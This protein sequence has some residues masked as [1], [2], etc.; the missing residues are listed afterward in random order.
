MADIVIERPRPG[1]GSSST[2]E[3]GA[4]GVIELIGIPGAG[5]TT[6]AGILEDVLRD[7]GLIPYDVVSA[8]RVYAK[9]TWVG[10]VLGRLLAG[11]VLSRALWGVYLAYSWAYVPYFAFRNPRLVRNIVVSQARR[12]GEADVAERRVLFWY[13]RL[14]GSHGF[15][16]SR[17]YPGEVLVLDE[18][19]VHRV[20]Q[21]H[22]SDVERPSADAIEAYLRLVPVPTAV[23]HVRAPRDVCLDRI[24][25]RGLWARYQGDDGSKLTGFLESAD[26][27]VRMAVEAMDRLGWSVEHV[28]NSGDM[29]AIRPKLE[30]LTRTGPV[31]A[32]PGA[33]PNR[34]R[35]LYTVCLPRPGFVREI[36][37]A[38]LRPPAV[39]HEE[40]GD[41]LSRF[42]H[43][44]VIAVANLPMGWR[45][46]NVLVETERG[47]R[48]L[49]QYPQRWT[50]DAIR[51][52]HSILGRLA[53]VGFPAP[54][55]VS[56]SEGGTLVTHAGSRWSLFERVDGSNLGA[57]LIR[58]RERV[59]L[60]YLAGRLLA[61]FH[62]ELS[63]FTPTGHHHLGYEDDEGERHI[64]LSW[65]L[66]TLRDLGENPG[67]SDGADRLKGRASDLAERLSTLDEA[68]T[69]S[70]VSKTVIHGDY[71]F[72]NLLYRRD[73]TAS[74]LDFELARIDLRLIDLVRMLSR[75]RPYAGRSF[76]AGYR[77]E[78]RISPGEWQ[79]LPEV[80][81]FYR[82]S[83][84]VRSWHLGRELGDPRR[85]AVARQRIDEAEW[86]L[87]NRLAPWEGEAHE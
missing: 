57:C 32:D 36:L 35:P 44:H 76:A 10:R 49:R 15:L 60:T 61:R 31:G 72:H 54:R 43:E 45:S 83:G 80:W 38:S 42:G 58:P 34:S 9:R 26:R 51:F 1:Q 19:F 39:S 12:P 65:Y 71:G 67:N 68:L 14:I 22:A 47:E 6:V 11:S 66:R 27:A 21:L 74:V 55:L 17:A 33:A 20:V 77:M 87:E 70:P 62:R 69:S 84:A 46:R 82:L 40:A 81:A 64:D 4:P 73:G 7:E 13:A 25:N 41:V 5:K 28:D 79:Q 30:T 86:I 37:E 48:V 52:E 78:S 24:R 63:G 53:D 16:L 23:I 56:T 59:R 29:A 8:A 2:A 50:S 85:F 3:T 18:G 75:Q